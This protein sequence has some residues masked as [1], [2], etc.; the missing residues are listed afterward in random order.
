MNLEMIVRPEA[1]EDLAETFDWYESR[2]RGLGS[3]FARAVEA[4]FCSILRNPRQYPVVYR[5]AHRA[6]VRRFPYR[7]HFVIE[8]QRIVVI[9]VTHARRDPEYWHGRMR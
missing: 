4:A 2:Q 3:E 5:E 8:S 9:A 6:P 1:E 7:V